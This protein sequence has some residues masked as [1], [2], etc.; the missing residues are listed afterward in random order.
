[1][2]GFSQQI[3]VRQ[4]PHRV[5]ELLGDMNDLDRWN[6]GVSS[7]RRTR[8]DRWELGSRYESTIARSLSK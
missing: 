3:K 1:M 2:V 6:P 7:S 5:F 4:P 8:G